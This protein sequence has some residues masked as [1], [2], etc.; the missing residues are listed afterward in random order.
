MTI[1]EVLGG[2]S[3]IVALA[4]LWVMMRPTHRLAYEK[5]TVSL[6]AVDSSIAG[7][8]RVLLEDRKVENLTLV[9]VRIVNIG[10]QPIRIEDYSDPIQIQF[11]GDTQ[12][13]S[14]EI[15]EVNP[16][17]LKP[18]L[19]LDAPADAIGI[20]PLLLNP[21]DAFT[22]KLLTA[23][24]TT[25][26]VITGRIAHVQR[27]ERLTGTG[28]GVWPFVGI[29]LPAAVLI[30][31]GSVLP[32]LG[33]ADGWTGLAFIASLFLAVNLVLVI[34]K[35]SDWMNPRRLRRQYDEH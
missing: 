29:L 2:I 26:P 21:R 18:L 19:N 24:A 9:R 5:E 33:L 27:I 31:I 25:S 23:G 11:Q 7:R 14:A 16:S 34:M 32:T 10:R 22:L 17:D 4:T 8:V 6:I 3:V 1:P 35:I 30:A 20:D 15:E 28:Y 12:L 13:V